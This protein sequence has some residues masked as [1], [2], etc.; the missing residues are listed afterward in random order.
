MIKTIFSGPVAK[1]YDS[2]CAQ[3]MSELLSELTSLKE[4]QISFI[5]NSLAHRIRKEYKLDVH[6]PFSINFRYSDKPIRTICVALHRWN[7]DQTFLQI[8]RR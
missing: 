7:K 2:I 4:R 5:A 8:E 3:V 1:D 6:L